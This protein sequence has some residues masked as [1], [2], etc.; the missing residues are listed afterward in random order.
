MYM[1]GFCRQ[2][3]TVYKCNTYT[4]QIKGICNATN[5]MLVV[6][7]ATIVEYNYNKLPAHFAVCVQADNSLRHSKIVLSLFMKLMQAVK[8]LRSYSLDKP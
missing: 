3:Y 5:L 2:L 1:V 8:L 7:F 4:P 6:E